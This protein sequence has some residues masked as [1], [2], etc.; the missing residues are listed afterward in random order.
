MRNVSKRQRSLLF[1]VALLLPLGFFL[2]GGAE[3]LAGRIGITPTVMAANSGLAGAKSDCTYEHHG[4]AFGGAVVVDTNETECGNL[5]TFGGKVAIN[6]VVKGDIVAF[7]S[8]VVIRGTVDGNIELYGG[9][10]ILQSGSHVHG[11]INLYGG[12]WTQGTSTQMDGAVIDRTEHV[13][14]LL[15]GNGGF[16]FSVWSLLIWVGL[17]ILF[18]SLFPE[19]VMLVRTTVVSKARRSFVIGLLSILLA[20]P[21]LVVLIALVLSIPLAII[22]GL[23]LIAAWALGTVAIGWHIGDY[24][25]RKVAPHQNTRL[26]QLVVGLTVLVLAGS[27]PY[28]GWLISIGAGL[29]GLGAVF[30]SRFGTRLY[31]QPKQPLTL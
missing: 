2:G 4:P 7:N 9:N 24:I 12:H 19:H 15:L 14:S 5:T 22:V 21:V 23:G 28:I 30:L 17:G 27:L 16:R 18:T 13:D 20:P 11:D 3:L 10:V 29:L 25:M 8:D 6:G 31:D 26:M 1:L